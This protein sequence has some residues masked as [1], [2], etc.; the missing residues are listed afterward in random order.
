M[1]DPT[2]PPEADHGV[3]AVSASPPRT[4]LRGQAS[5][6]MSPLRPQQLVSEQ[7]ATTMDTEGDLLGVEELNP[8][9]THV[10]TTE[11][12][13]SD[14]SVSIDD[15][16]TAPSSIGPTSTGPQTDST[17]LGRLIQNTRKRLSSGPNEQDGADPVY[18]VEGDVP[19][20]DDNIYDG[21]RPLI[22][23]YLH[24]L[25]RNGK[26]QRRFFETDGE[27]LSY[28][29]SHKRVKLLATLDLFKVRICMCCYCCLSPVLT[30][31]VEY[32]SEPLL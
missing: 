2:L 23:G 5:P 15:D 26:W 29:K 30:I 11:N 24:K 18:N 32:R 27:S 25:G 17:L 12:R 20:E 22:Y 10:N 1:T 14:G 7:S 16:D 21:Q 9:S 6:V 3:T 13:A 28:F 4:P 31:C 19:E 8:T